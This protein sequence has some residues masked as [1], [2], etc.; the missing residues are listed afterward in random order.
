MCLSGPKA[1]NVRAAGHGLRGHFPASPTFTLTRRRHDAAHQLRR[2]AGADSWSR[3]ARRQPMTAKAYEAPWCAAA[4]GS[5]RASSGT[6]EPRS[7]ADNEECR[8]SAACRGLRHVMDVV[9]QRKE[10]QW[11]NEQLVVVL[12]KYARSYCAGQ[13]R[14]A[15]CM[16][17]AR[18]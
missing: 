7:E 11:K 3:R 12:Y 6:D 4:K 9:V 15:S 17:V 14:N 18:P 1:D 8:G 2:T 16:R 10:P 13:V 5:Q